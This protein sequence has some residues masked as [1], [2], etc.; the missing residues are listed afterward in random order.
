MEEQPNNHIEIKT[1]TVQAG[2]LKD[3]DTIFMGDEEYDVVEVD[4][5]NRNSFV[6]IKNRK[7]EVKDL[8]AYHFVKRAIL[9]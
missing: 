8:Y 2:F 7:G 9:D 6:K 1:E 3:G 4:T 5:Q